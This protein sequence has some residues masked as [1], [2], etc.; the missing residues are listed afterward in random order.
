M[1][2]DTALLPLEEIAEKILD[3]ADYFQ[4]AADQGEG[5]LASK[6]IDPLMIC[7]GELL[8]RA[9]RLNCPVCGYTEQDAAFHRDH[10][11][12]ENKTP[13]WENVARDELLDVIDKYMSDKLGGNILLCQRQAIKFT[14]EYLSNQTP[15][16]DSAEALEALNRLDLYT[17]KDNK[18]EEWLNAYETIRA[19][20]QASAWQPIET[21]PRDGTDVQLWSKRALCPV[22]GHYNS[23]E[24]FEKEYGDKNYME[25]GWYYSFKYPFD[26]VLP[27]YTLENPTHWMPLPQS[28]EDED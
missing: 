14:L 24:Y 28:P 20:L 4:S 18:C 19:A 1:T 7:H 27:E 25:E 11:L 9:A 16:Q 8:K 17:G 13:P 2:D 12:C 15:P 26:E 5:F 22:Y 3:A 10:N 21:A 6:I 23:A